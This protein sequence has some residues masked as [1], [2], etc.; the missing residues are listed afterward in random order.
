[1][2]V[3]LNTSNQHERVSNVPFRGY[4]PTKNEFGFK[5]Y[6]F[7]YPFDEDTQN[8]YLEVYSVNFDP[9]ENFRIENLLHD[10]N[11]LKRQKLSPGSNKFNFARM[12]GL[13]ANAPFAY[14]YVV[15]N[16]NN[17]SDVKIRIDA[18][19]SVD[20]RPAGHSQGDSRIYNVVNPKKSLMSK[21][22]SMKLIIPDAQNVGVEY[23]KDGKYVLNKKKKNASASLVKNL[24]NRLGGNLAGVEKDIDDGQYDMYSRI[25]SL[26][27]FGRDRLSAHGY[28]SEELFQIAPHIGNINNYSSVQRKLF[29]HG[30]NLVA[31]GA[32]V[33][34]G[35][36][37][38][39]FS[40]ILRYGENSPFFNWFNGTSLEGKVWNLGIFPKNSTYTSH[41]TVNFP[42]IYKQDR[43]GDIRRYKNPLYDS[44]KSHDIQYFDKR[45]VSEEQAN[46]TQNVISSYTRQPDNIYL[47]NSYNDSLYPYHISVNPEEYDKNISCLIEYN[48]AH[49]NNIIRIDSYEGARMLSKFSTWNAD[50]MFEGG[51]ETWNANPDIPKLKFVFSTEDYKRLKNLS[52]EERKVESEKI[53]RANAQVRD[54]T[55]EAGKYWTRMTNDIHRLYIAQ[56]LKNISNNADDAG[57]L[58]RTI[59]DKSDDKIFPRSL[60]YEI[61]KNEVENVL[62]GVYNYSRALSQED[63]QEQVLRHIMD[64]PLESLEFGSNIISSLATPYI[65][66][67]AN[68]FDEIGMS[69]YDLYK[70]GTPNLEEKYR[71]L[72]NKTEDIMIKGIYPV[73]M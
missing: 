56:N 31:D 7:S 59:L 58:Y 39:H 17:P 40:H 54:Y 61:S 71:K 18:G 33:N 28:W 60:K 22:G 16:K 67:R 37:G 42:L 10:N 68:T 36:Q 26:P 65:S 29:A 43:Y 44:K 14:H 3:V 24:W 62:S 45:L 12:F 1:M 70:N 53:L 2:K 55:I 51:F 47:L 20:N 32:F 19:D 63:K 64:F 30:I 15:E 5:E 41:K 49:P 66:K 13:D 8:C 46:D 11:G 69:R 4:K 38:V 6:E 35:I 23:A 48:K 72:Y 73:V 9:Y 57:L 25:L 34:E 50:E 27:I 52:P 21:G